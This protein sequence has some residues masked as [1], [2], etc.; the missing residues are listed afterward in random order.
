MILDHRELENSTVRRCHTV[1]KKRVHRSYI[2]T[3][4]LKEWCDDQRKNG[5]KNKKHEGFLVKL[6]SQRVN[7]DL[8]V[9]EKTEPRKSKKEIKTNWEKKFVFPSM[10]TNFFI[11]QI[12]KYKH[13]QI[14]LVSPQN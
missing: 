14:S 6:N 2:I 13:K 7:L 3:L 8:P 9:T 11:G 4:S 10:V 1:S 5:K 12:D